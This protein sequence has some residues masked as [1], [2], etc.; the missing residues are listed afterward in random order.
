MKT[1]MYQGI[2]K[3]MFINGSYNIWKKKLYFKVLLLYKNTLRNV[4]SFKV[5]RFL[6]KFLIQ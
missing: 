5:G 4:K 6:F 1:I 2:T 3:F